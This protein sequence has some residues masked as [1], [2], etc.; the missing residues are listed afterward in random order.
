[1]KDLRNLLP[2]FLS[3][4]SGDPAV[5]LVFLQ[6]LWP[7]VVGPHVA[8]WTRPEGLRSKRLVC[9]VLAPDWEEELA[10]FAPVL[11]GAINQFWDAPLVD[12]IEFVV[13]L[14]PE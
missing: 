7:Q 14:D 13:H 12:R 8:R 4:I 3:R 5:S 11:I 2:G 6:E 10:A 9:R 1:M